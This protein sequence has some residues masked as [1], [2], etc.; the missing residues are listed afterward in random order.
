V[1]RTLTRI[2]D[3]RVCR[4]R[5]SSSCT[6]LSVEKLKSQ[7]AKIACDGRLIFFAAQRVRCACFVAFYESTPI[8]NMVLADNTNTYSTLIHVVSFLKLESSQVSSNLYRNNRQP[9]GSLSNVL[10]KPAGEDGSRWR[11]LDLTCLD[12]SS[13]VKSIHKQQTTIRKPI[14]CAPEASAAVKDGSGRRLT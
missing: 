13:L 14:E 7:F 12:L 11:C 8:P 6:R 5:S 4:V 2:A 1:A 10:R 3:G 9:Y